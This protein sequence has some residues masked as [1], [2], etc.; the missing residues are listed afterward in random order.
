MTLDIVVCFYLLGLF[1][2]LV[3]SDLRLPK[4]LYDTLT[5][6]LLLTIGLKG[7]VELSKHSVEGLGVQLIVLVVLGAAL[8]LLAFPALRWVGRFDRND[9][10]CIA[11]HYGSVSV[12]T[13]AVAIAFLD[14]AGVFY[15]PHAAIFVVMMEMPAIAVGILLAKGLHADARWGQL[16]HEVFLNKGML[17]MGGGVLIGMLLG[18]AGTQ[19]VQPFFFDL[20]KGVLALFLLEMGMVTAD[21][22][23]DLKK[24]GLFLLGF[25]IVMPLTGASVGAL[26]GHWLD[27]SV[28]G[29]ALLATL[30]ASASYIAVPAAMRIALPQARHGI[31]IAASLG[32]TF[33]F[34]VAIGI[35]LY[36]ELARWV[37]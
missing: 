4:G 33:P 29:I 30:A 15:E 18:D 22:V 34:N 23:P 16:S 19:S 31:A 7:G 24:C 8:A 26:T 5:I 27:L 14:Q 25:G 3:R 10:A 28:G 37:G 17:L 2:G 36:L 21:H 35:P 1:A 20:F 11:A 12:G 13:F 9:A 32:V 6:M